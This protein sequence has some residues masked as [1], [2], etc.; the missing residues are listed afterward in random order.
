MKKIF[1]IALVLTLVLSLLT[2]CGGNRGGN[3]G[4]GP[5]DASGENPGGS[6]Q[7]AAQPGAEDVKLSLDKPSYAAG[8]KITVAVS[9]VTEQM[10]NDRAFVSIYKAGAGHDE[11]G[12]F[13][14]LQVGSGILLLDA[15][16]EHGSYE[17]RLYSEDFEYRD[18]TLI[19]KAP[20]TVGS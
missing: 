2:A 17:M 4:G 15:P 1:A 19:A 5:I 8:G 20:F 9:G 13:E 10:V 14:Y 18:E 6:S 7:P 3:G 11:Y 12:Q 16:E